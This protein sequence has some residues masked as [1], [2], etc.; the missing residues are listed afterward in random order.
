MVRALAF[1]LARLWR[2]AGVDLGDPSAVQTFF[3][4]L[5]AGLGSAQD[6]ATIRRVEAVRTIRARVVE[7]F[8]S[9]A[10]ESGH[11]NLDF[12]NEQVAALT[13]AMDDVRA[14]AP[15]QASLTE[16]RQAIDPFA[17][18]RERLD[19]PIGTVRAASSRLTQVSLELDDAYLEG[20]PVVVRAH[21][22][23][24]G[25]V[26]GASFVDVES[27][28]EVERLPM[29]PTGDGGHSVTFRPPQPGAY[30]VSISGNNTQVEVA[31]DAFEVV[32]VD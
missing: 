19:Q 18:V 30:R 28:R 22:S 21:T 29:T 6:L 8:P 12:L 31:T 32:A 11:S 1:V 26:V 15:S 16:L 25:V 20:Q 9:A 5:H 3:D 24:A 13:A 27:G 17:G 23:R 14:I 2:D 4:R 10:P 7:H